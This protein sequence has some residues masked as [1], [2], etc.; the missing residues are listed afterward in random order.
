[1][2][3]PALLII[4][5]SRGI[6]AA[7]AQLAGERGY[8]VALTYQRDKDAA[9]KVA[10]TIRKAGRKAVT[11]QADAGREEDALRT[12]ETVDKEFG[13]L[14]AFIYNAGIN[15]RTARLED[16]ETE[17][18][19]RVLDTNTLGAMINAREAVKRMSTNRGGRGGAIVFIGSRAAEYGAPNNF[20][21][22]AASKGAIESLT[23]G[24]AR[25]VGVDGIRVNCAAPGPIH[26]DMSDPVRTP[27]IIQTT[28]L[29][30]IGEPR[31]VATVALF[32]CSEDASF[33]TGTVVLV[34]G[35]R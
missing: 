14:D 6:G 4:G 13:R 34:G 15:G 23:R 1:M 24:L 21:W 30:R 8:D 26:T 32:L 9:E 35:G 10:E 25:E 28:A 29:K 3:A 7:T 22:Y 19:R 20:V 5:G 2:S 16:I 11:I 17:V 27:Q 31:E 18:L 12:F 33:T